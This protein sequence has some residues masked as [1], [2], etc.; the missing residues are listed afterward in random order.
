MADSLTSGPLCFPRFTTPP[1]Q[2]GA[3][4]VKPKGEVASKSNRFI[5]SS[6]KLHQLIQKN[7]QQIQKCH[8]QIQKKS[9]RNPKKSPRNPYHPP[10]QYGATKVKPKGD[11][12]SKPNKFYFLFGKT[13][14]KSIE[15]VKWN[16]YY[17]I[18]SN[19]FHLKV[20]VWKR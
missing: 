7:H 8:Q 4:A 6:E 2:Y 18:S 19:L 16:L 13:W 12:P 1:T 5:F 17:E 10:P 3:T 9:L 14:L 20:F 15:M 11:V